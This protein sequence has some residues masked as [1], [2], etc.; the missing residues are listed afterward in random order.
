MRTLFHRLGLALGLCVLLLNAEG[1]RVAYIAGHEIAGEWDAYTIS[2]GAPAIAIVCAAL[3]IALIVALSSFVD[4]LETRAGRIAW[5][6]IAVMIAVPFA[7]ELSTG[8]KARVPMFRVPFVI[9]VAIAFAVVAGWIAPWFY[10]HRRWWTAPLLGI[11]VLAAALWADV[12]I[13]PRLYPVFHQSLLAVMAIGVVLI[14]DGFRALPARVVDV[15]AAL[16]I[17]FAALAARRV[18]AAGRDLA[19]YD[20]ARRILDEKSVLLARVVELAAKKWPPPPLDEGTDT[21]DPLAMASVRALDA[22]GRDLLLITIDAVRADH[23]GAYGYARKTTPAIDALAREGVVFEH[24]YTPT[25]HTSY[26]ISSLMTGKYMRPILALEAASGVA[27]KPDET[28]A[29]LFRTYGFRTA[30]FYPPAIWA[31]DADR[32]KPLIERKID[33]EYEKVEFAAPDLRRKQVGEYV[34]AVPKNKPLFVWV[35]LFEPHEPYV[36]HAGHDFGANEIDRYDSEIAAAD[37][38]V[39]GMISDFRAARPGAIVIVSADHGEA[40]GEHGARYHGTTVYEEQ[41]RVPL[42]VSAPGLIAPRRI[43]RPVQLIDL[44]PTVVSAYGIPR[45]PRVRGMD[46]GALLAGRDDGQEGIAFSEVEDMAMLARGPL[47]LLC[48]RKTSTCPLF[49]VTNDPLQLTALINDP[50]AD[51]LRKEMGAVIAGSARLEGFADASWPEALRRGFAGDATAAIEVAALLDDVDVSF[52]RRASEVLARLASRDTESHV[53][54]ALGKETDPQT[55]KWLAIAR[56]RTSKEHPATPAEIAE[57]T[58][59]LE[60]SEGRWAALALGEVSAGTQRAFEL[61]VDWFPTARADAELG[62][63]ILRVLP[64]MQKKT[65]ADAKRATP[66]L[67]EALGDVRLRVEAVRALGLLGDPAAIPILEEKIAGERHVDARVPEVLALAQLGRADRALVHIVRYLGVPEPPP[68]AAD[69]LLTI[70]REVPPPSWVAATKKARLVVPQGAA[71]RLI[72]VG[73]KDAK[74]RVDGEELAGG[75]IVE[76]GDRV[77]KKPSVDVTVD[78]GTLLA[79][80]PRVDDLP[81]PKPD[82]TLDEEAPTAPH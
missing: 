30:A 79:L 5:G 56:L 33:F 23:V 39:G 55:K 14:A 15:G 19:K 17:V 11:A 25:P 16:G 74:V 18:P 46:L 54:R 50:R 35:H 22:T 9:A 61:L 36:T 68:G 80:V 72:V 51:R 53:R 40:F 38:G 82:R 28:W 62:R 2:R 63:A 13:L 66:A 47:R 43:A 58:A 27:R 44:L 69:A 4:L 34:A 75:P 37:A 60:G 42:I 20:N 70:V 32:F 78:Q 6:A 1:S 71:H 29:L 8:R 31:V 26:A 81:P 65:N 12:R 24:A 41:V 77:A 52:R 10:R 64:P 73:A 3:A 48:N 7:L 57:V 67:K 76:L 21:P 59:L 49:D 45:P